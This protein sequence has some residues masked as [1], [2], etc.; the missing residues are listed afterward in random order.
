MKLLLTLD[1]P[2]ERGGIQ[3]YL[4]DKVAHTFEAGDAV[5][6][7][8]ATRMSKEPAGLS[9]PIVR[10]ANPLS[11]LNKKW[12]I[13]NL[14]FALRAALRRS[15][16]LLEIRCG[17]VYA[18]IAPW[19]LGRFRPV[20]YRVY[21]YGGE[22]LILQKRGPWPAL[23]RRVLRGA[24]SL[25][26]LG[27]FGKQLLDAAGIQKPVA[28]DPPRIEMPKALP[29]VHRAKGPL[30]LLSVG[31]LVPH[32]GHATLLAAVAA[33]PATLDWRL[34]IAGVGPEEE[35]LRR[36]VDDLKIKDRVAI[37]CDLDDEALAR[38]YGGADL[39]ILPSMTT[40]TGVEG[41]G[42]VLLEAMAR[43]VPVVASNIGGIP[44]VL[45]N[46]RCGA[47]V[48]PGDAPA[49]ARAILDL[50]QSP[51]RRRRFA[52]EALQRLRERYAW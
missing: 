49:L 4:F 15:P 10:V 31:R 9:C 25:S 26:V 32:K 33:L 1:F 24:E 19:F 11:R 16:G 48:P 5:L 47:L 39:F 20:R 7:G 14:V 43:G 52:A 29:D 44:E 38:E 8:A 3:R 51:D 22:L 40:P 17:N 23:L 27:E 13:V 50:V 2:P 12:S 28:V 18:A 35:R 34:T 36:C 46:G 21:T 42:I 6:V 45:D 41:F 30:R 37:R